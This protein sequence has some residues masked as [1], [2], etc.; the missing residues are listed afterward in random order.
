MAPLPSSR[1]LAQTLL[2]QRQPGERVVF[3]GGYFYD[4]PFYARLD[5]PAAVVEDW[6][7]P[8]I[9]QRDN[10]RKE[11]LDASHFAPDGGAQVLAGAA[12][13]DTGACAATST[14]V[15]ATAAAA[16]RYGLAERAVP[17]ARSGDAGLWRIAPPAVKA[18]DCRG[19]P[20]VD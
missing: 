19:K 5:R 1:A 2:K 10:W 9:G 7:D 18:P 16:A 15:V 13:L 3:A 14:W 17:I 12:R 11:L 8:A 4:L 6:D 20:S